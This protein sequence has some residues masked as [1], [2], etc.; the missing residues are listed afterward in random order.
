MQEEIDGDHSRERRRILRSGSDSHAQNHNTAR[1]HQAGD[2]ST[3]R[4]SREPTASGPK[5]EHLRNSQQESSDLAKDFEQVNG[6]RPNRKGRSRSHN[7]ERDPA[8]TT[9]RL[10]IR[11]ISQEPVN[12]SPEHPTAAGSISHD[13][14]T[15]I[16]MQNDVS[17]VV[18]TTNGQ[19]QSRNE[20]IEQRIRKPP[21]SMLGDYFGQIISGRRDRQAIG[22]PEKSTTTNNVYINTINNAQQGAL[23]T[24][25]PPSTETIGVGLIDPQK[26]GN[27]GVAAHGW[28]NR[29]LWSESSFRSS[30]FQRSM[31]NRIYTRLSCPSLSGL[32][33]F[34][35][36]VAFAVLF[37]SCFVAPEWSSTWWRSCSRDE[38]SL[39]CSTWISPLITVCNP[40]PSKTHLN[41]SSGSSDDVISQY[42]INVTRTWAASINESDS[43]LALP[44]ALQKSHSKIGSF[45]RQVQDS[46]L[47]SKEI[48]DAQLDDFLTR[49]NE[50]I[51][52]L[53]DFNSIR[54]AIFSDVSI[55]LQ[56]F[57][58]RLQAIVEAYNNRSY[59]EQAKYWML[60]F[61]VEASSDHLIINA[62]T[63]F[64]DLLDGIAQDIDKKI[65]G[66]GQI[67]I[68]E[69][70]GLSIDLDMVDK[71]CR[72]ESRR[73]TDIQK[74]E[75][76]FR[77]QSWTWLGFSKPIDNSEVFNTQ[78]KLL[79]SFHTAQKLTED[80]LNEAV[81]VYKALHKDMLHMKRQ[82]QRPDTGRLFRLD[83]VMKWMQHLLDALA[84]LNATKAE[85]LEKRLRVKA[86]INR[87]GEAFLA[88][89]AVGLT[90]HV[91]SDS[92]ITH[93]SEID[94]GTT[95][96][97]RDGRGPAG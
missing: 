10:S 57:D 85:E 2:E 24:P 16:C 63:T 77:N 81:L 89:G 47:E 36:T 91:K 50:A 8:A 21:Y 61:S 88:I 51:D 53:I 18:P 62:Y 25:L 11:E 9:S 6:D 31:D 52:D 73:I 84:R 49:L 87:S 71:M 58:L 15:N 83:L 54:L 69:I 44:R 40:V 46:Q 66:K 28:P 82:L 74:R 38:R 76:A 17:N 55:K 86:Q 7:H 92:V 34:F 96:I 5:E 75:E 35:L 79:D 42:I 70:Q 56:S 78:Q 4:A 43:A 90:W 93:P 27:F 95:N 37:G 67:L 12:E 65:L 1:G 80:N 13:Q 41:D 68:A 33:L 23:T 45:L 20:I 26:P 72:S 19:S 32:M 60:S 39:V 22:S 59:W 48:V 30:E 64:A 97:L 29:P 14:V 3:S 94:P